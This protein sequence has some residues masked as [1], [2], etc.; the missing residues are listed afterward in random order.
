MGYLSENCYLCKMTDSAGIAQFSCGDKDLDEFFR[1]DSMAYCHQLLGKTYLYRMKGTPA[2]IVGAFT[3]ANASIR[4]DDLPNSRKKKLEHDIPYKKSCRNYPAVL[5]GR[6]GVGLDF[7]SLHLGS[8][9][10]DF[11]KYW[12]VEPNN[13][14]GC[15]FLLVD[16]YNHAST[17]RFYERNGFKLLFS[18]EEQE[19]VYRR[20]A[21]EVSLGTR[22]MYFDLIG[23]N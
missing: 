13:K 15:R 18:S 9:I 5:I 7:Q 22:I 10:L 21:P 12:F 3:I 1:E 6:L 14:T 23:L 19:K 20:L 11:I 2:I 8:E 17:I 4:V 16:S